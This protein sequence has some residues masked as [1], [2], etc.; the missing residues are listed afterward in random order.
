M[1]QILHVV[2]PG[3]PHESQAEISQRARDG[4]ERPAEDVPGIVGI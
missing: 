3:Q 2:A 4:V 1:V